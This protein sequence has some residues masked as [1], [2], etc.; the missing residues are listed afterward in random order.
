MNV[1]DVKTN[2]VVFI[3][4]ISIKLTKIKNSSAFCLFSNKKIYF[5]FEFHDF[6][7]I[8]NINIIYIFIYFLIIYILLFFIKIM[9]RFLTG[10]R[11]PPVYSKR[12]SP[13]FC[14]RGCENLV[15]RWEKRWSPVA[16]KIDGRR[17]RW[18]TGGH[19]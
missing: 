18:K 7:K 17:Y 14:P 15:K 8:Q 11:W 6:N 4:K 19:R 10:E 13:F 5:L 1:F 3:I 12:S 2:Y 9:Q 16:V